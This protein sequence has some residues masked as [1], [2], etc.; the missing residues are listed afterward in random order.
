[1]TMVCGNI[2][3]AL[4]QWLVRN[5]RSTSVQL[6]GQEWSVPNHFSR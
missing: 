6:T 1:M 5:V 2:M 3:E 4:A